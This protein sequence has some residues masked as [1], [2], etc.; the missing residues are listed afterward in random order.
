MGSGK[1]IAAIF[2][3]LLSMLVLLYEIMTFDLFG[4][5]PAYYSFIKLFIQ[6]EDLSFLLAVVLPLIVT[7]LILFLGGSGAS[8]RRGSP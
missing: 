8:G 1:I 4:I 5:V 2:P 6:N 3:L 7:T